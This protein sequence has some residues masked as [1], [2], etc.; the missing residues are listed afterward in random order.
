MRW[1][2]RI[3]VTLV[4]LAVVVV[5][6]L[7]LIP[8]DRIAR[9][10]ETQFENNTGRALVITGGVQPTIYPRLGVSLEGVQIANASW[11]DQGPMLV[12]D[13]IDMGVG[14]SGLIGGDIVV[15]AFTIENPVIRLEKSADGSENWKF[16]TEFGSDEPGGDTD[17]S[18]V[19]L[20]SAT[21]TGGTL[22]YVDRQ[23]GVTHVLDD[24]AVDLSA[25]DLRGLVEFSFAA[26]KE[27]QPFSVNGSLDGV[28]QLLNGG[29]QPAELVFATGGSLA[30]FKGKAAM[31]PV[32]GAGQLSL[33]IADQKALFGL[34]GQT[35]PRI[36]QG[37]GQHPKLTGQ[38]TLTPENKIFLRDAVIDLDQN[39]FQGDFDVE[40]AD[41]P[42][43]TARV[44]GDQIDFSAMSTDT[45]EG[46]GAANA[47][48]GGWSEAF[49]DVSGIGAVD[50]SFAMDVNGLDLGSVQLGKTKISGTIDNS[51]MVLNLGEVSVFDGNVAGQFVVNN[52]SGL[53]VGGDMSASNVAMQSLLRDFMGYDRLLGD[54]QMRLK[55]LASGSNMNALMNSLSGSGSLAVGTGE[56]QGLDIAGMIKNLDSSYQGEGAKTV[57]NSITAS[58]DIANGVLRNDDL[59]FQA[60]LLTATGAGELGIGAQTV[61][62]RVDPVALAAQLSKGIRVPVIIEGPWSNVRFRPDLKSL[63]D[64]EL[65]DKKEALKAQAKAKEEELKAAARAKAAEKLGVPSD[66]EQSL[67]DQ[68]KE[69]AKSKLLDLLGGN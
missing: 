48:A 24:V 69:K 63:V 21:I 6:G 16:L 32:Q 53:S 31:D 5:A 25:A 17:L 10:A 12:A 51:R 19:S 39:R 61:N 33:D 7:F 59:N 14:L 45:T 66:P 56:I 23:A 20:P 49:L 34:L 57:F 1:I 9:F 67:E 52:R 54:A 30:S 65:E 44:S 41:K 50:G 55:F 64:T 58:F 35:P 27:G 4:I 2:A 11:S 40:L 60:D 47:G 26:I 68:L 46:D 38:I 22:S 29:L 43:V 3:L 18:A 42:I 62:Y 37:M 15:E 8:S 36:P 28:E 13:A